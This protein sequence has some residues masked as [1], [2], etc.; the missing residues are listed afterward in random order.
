MTATTRIRWTED[1]GVV[2]WSGTIGV[3]P[4]HQ[5]VIIRPERGSDEYALGCLLPGMDGHAYGN[6]DELKA[7]AERW[8]E[9]YV[10]SLGAVFPD[11]PAK[12]D[13]LPLIGRDLVLVR[14]L[15]DQINR[16]GVNG[17]AAT[18]L[19]DYGT[20]GRGFAFDVLIHAEGEDT[21]R[22]AKVTVVLDRVEG[23]G[24]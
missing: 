7:E 1:N 16:H 11:E 15:A 22:V 10:A 24:S 2:A 14:K 23:T 13:R 3:I 19:N 8:L 17:H 12:E 4:S 21:G 18:Q 9:E 20:A 6:P 5:F